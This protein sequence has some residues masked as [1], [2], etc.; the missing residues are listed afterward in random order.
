MKN[1]DM[2]QD[3]MEQDDMG[4]DEMKKNQQGGSVRWFPCRADP[5]Y[6]LITAEIRENG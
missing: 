5:T 4:K 1:D 6:R 2:E 3:D